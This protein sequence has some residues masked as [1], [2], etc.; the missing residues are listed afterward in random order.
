QVQDQL[1][2]AK[3]R[4]AATTERAESAER[5]RDELSGKLE[6]IRKDVESYKERAVVAEAKAQQSEAE[7]KELRKYLDS[8]FA[9][10]KR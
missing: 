6:Q 3:A 1:A 9:Q 10:L 4:L 2:E 5:E 7:R 8:K